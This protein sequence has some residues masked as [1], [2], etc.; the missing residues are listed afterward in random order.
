MTLAGRLREVLA[1]SRLLLHRGGRFGVAM[2]AADRSASQELGRQ[3]NPKA[4]RRPA[5]EP[6]VPT[7]HVFLPTLQTGS[8]VVL[9]SQEIAEGEMVQKGELLA[10]LECRKANYPYKSPATGLVTWLMQP[11]QDGPAG[12]KLAEIET[13]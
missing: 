10:L 5:Q 6:T 2:E 9:V 11:G 13:E 7:V 1:Q 4:D 3:T 8:A 12:A